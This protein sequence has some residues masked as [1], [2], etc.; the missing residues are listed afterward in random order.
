[1]RQHRGQRGSWPTTRRNEMKSL[2]RTKEELQ[3]MNFRL[4]S[5]EIEKQNLRKRRKDCKK[6]GAFFRGTMR[7]EQVDFEIKWANEEKRRLEAGVDF[8]NYV[9][10]TP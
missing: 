5:L 9:K 1:M 4:K 3:L 2:A 6:I 8:L 10:K 7:L